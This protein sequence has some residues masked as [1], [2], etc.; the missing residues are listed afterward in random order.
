MLEYITAILAREHESE[1]VRGFVSPIK[2]ESDMDYF[3][4]KVASGELSI[5][6][7]G[8]E[9]Y[10]AVQALNKCTKML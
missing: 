8:P 10:D 1:L 3:N 9:L 7:Q 2:K 6:Y 5:A 4:R